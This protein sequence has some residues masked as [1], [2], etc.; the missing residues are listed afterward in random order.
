VSDKVKQRAVEAILSNFRMTARL[1]LLFDDFFNYA[2][3]NNIIFK[4]RDKTRLHSYE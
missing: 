1:I 4:L 2:V 3:H